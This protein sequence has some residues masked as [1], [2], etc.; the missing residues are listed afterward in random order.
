M[1]G[2]GVFA[3]AGFVGGESVANIVRMLTAVAG[4]FV[5]GFVM[6]YMEKY[7]LLLT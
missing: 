3:L 5:V 4:S 6:T 1:G 2:M 7:L